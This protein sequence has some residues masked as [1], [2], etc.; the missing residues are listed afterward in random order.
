[1]E[2]RQRPTCLG[3]IQRCA[4][5][6]IWT[7]D[8]LDCTFEWAHPSSGPLISTSSA[9]HPIGPRAYFVAITKK[10]TVVVALFNYDLDIPKG[11]F[12]CFVR[13][14]RLCRVRVWTAKR[15]L[16]SGYTAYRPFL[17]YIAPPCCLQASSHL[18]YS[19]DGLMKSH[20][21]RVSKDIFI[22]PMLSLAFHLLSV[23]TTHSQKQ[24]PYTDTLVEGTGRL[25][26]HDRMY[27]LPKNGQEL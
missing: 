6:L 4:L 23:P 2:K 19:P 12:A 21:A 14:L 17:W 18:L 16:Q 11:R 20:S 9:Y 25:L 15:R 3:Q 7:Y 26:H 1:M 24:V 22:I 8:P 5:K 27:G 10:P 13:V